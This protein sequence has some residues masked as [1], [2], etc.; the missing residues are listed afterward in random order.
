M[1]LEEHA[2]VRALALALPD[3]KVLHVTLGE[4]V[5]FWAM[6]LGLSNREVLSV[7]FEEH[8]GNGPRTT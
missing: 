5:L 2:L 3:K 7:N 6:A 4:N 1:T 8:K